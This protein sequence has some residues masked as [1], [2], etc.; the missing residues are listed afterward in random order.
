MTALTLFIT[1]VIYFAL[2]TPISGKWR[3]PAF[4]IST[5]TIAVRLCSLEIVERRQA[6]DFTERQQGDPKETKDS[7]AVTALLTKNA[8]NPELFGEE[9]EFRKEK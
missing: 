6:S 8:R 4:R 7:A 5:Q 3:W 2:I 9:I 1:M